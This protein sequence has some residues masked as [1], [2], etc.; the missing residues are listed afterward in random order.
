MKC[1][2]KFFIYIKNE[3]KNILKEEKVKKTLHF[4]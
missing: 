2:K 1:I 3:M 4:S